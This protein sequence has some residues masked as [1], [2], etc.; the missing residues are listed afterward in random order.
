VRSRRYAAM[1]CRA[2]G[3]SRANIG[4]RG[5]SCT[6]VAMWQL[7]D[8]ESAQD[9]GAAPLYR[10]PSVS[11]YRL[12]AICHRPTARLQCAPHP[13][14]TREVRDI[15]AQARTPVLLVRFAQAANGRW[16]R[17]RRC[18]G[19]VDRILWH[20]GAG[21]CPS[22]A[23]SHGFARP[24]PHHRCHRRSGTTHPPDAGEL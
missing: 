17:H 12:A 13:V 8:W 2:C 21:S 24:G 19:V 10:K 18:C 7:T 11:T 9:S 4:T 22:L 15:Q 5:T 20:W 23:H 3:P 16:W 14:S 1:S 6:D